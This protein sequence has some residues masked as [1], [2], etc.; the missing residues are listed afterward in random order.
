MVLNYRSA[1]LATEIPLAAKCWDDFYP[2]E[3]DIVVDNHVDNEKLNQ[4][5]D[6]TY[7]GKE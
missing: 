6:Q 3:I 5:T 4:R 7:L 1:R 2:V